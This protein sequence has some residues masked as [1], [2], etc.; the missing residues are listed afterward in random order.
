M[1]ESVQPLIMSAEDTKGQSLGWAPF[2]TDLFLQR[3]KEDNGRF[4]MARLSPSFRLYHDPNGLKKG[5]RKTVDTRHLGQEPKVREAMGAIALHTPMFQHGATSSPTNLERLK[6]L[7]TALLWPLEGRGHVKAGTLDTRFEDT[8]IY[9]CQGGLIFVPKSFSWGATLKDY[10]YSVDDINTDSV[11]ALN[12]SQNIGAR[13]PNTPNCVAISPELGPDISSHTKLHVLQ[14][15]QR[16]ICFIV[17]LKSSK[18]NIWKPAPVETIQDP[19]FIGKT[20]V[21]VI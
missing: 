7:G 15:L 6:K 14:D 12:K 21:P 3:S 2:M 17:A 4:L 8:E 18:R 5:E 19:L 9:V 16:A 13:N 20:L 10:M 11:I 1:T